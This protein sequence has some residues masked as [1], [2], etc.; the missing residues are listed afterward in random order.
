MFVV[1]LTG[2][3][4]SG[5]SE[6]TRKLRE[7][8][9]EV[10]DAD[11]V[12][13]QAY[14]PQTETWQAVVNAFGQ[15]ILQPTGEIDRRKLGSIVFSDPKELARLNA[16]MHPR[17]FRMIQ[18]QLDELRAKGVQVAVV[19]AAILI[20][21]NWTPLVDEVWVTT[22]SEDVVVQRV[23]QRSNLPEEEVRRRIRSQLSN[24]E[25]AKHATVVI[26]NN[27]GM[28]ELRCEVQHLWESRVQGRAA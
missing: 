17:M 3:I 8:G 10:I 18:G 4:G 22:A 25:R 27:G 19:E 13:H 20:E 6:V 24:H 14:L 15:G 1:G 2:G 23:H 21:A 11:L 12:G 5:K 16:I 26:E 7:L 28:E 9:A